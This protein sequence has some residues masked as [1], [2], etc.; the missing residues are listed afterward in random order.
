[1]LD[2]HGW[3]ATIIVLWPE[4]AER[5]HARNIFPVGSIAEDPATGAAAAATGGYL[6]GSHAVKPPAS[7]VIYQ[8]SHV[9]R[10][11]QL[12]VQIPPS[13][14]IVVSGSAARIA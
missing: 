7:I 12:P 4:S 9:G 10:P 1:M 3:P 6:R 5:W 8:G 13:A 14:R 2:E 11:S